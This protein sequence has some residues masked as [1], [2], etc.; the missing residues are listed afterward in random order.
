MYTAYYRESNVAY[1]LLN[2]KGNTCYYNMNRCTYFVYK[3]GFVMPG[4]IAYVYS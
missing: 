1:K 3:P 4:K 2:S